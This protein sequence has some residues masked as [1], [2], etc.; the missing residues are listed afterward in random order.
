MNKD[1]EIHINKCN[2]NFST[3]YNEIAA[4]NQMDDMMSIQIGF[5]IFKIEKRNS[6]KI[7]Q[8]L[9]EMTTLDSVF[10]EEN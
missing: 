8:D 1:R 10:H 3:I 5:S 2:C 4:D 7:F 9:V 6:I